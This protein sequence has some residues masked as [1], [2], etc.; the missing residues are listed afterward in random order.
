MSAVRLGGRP[1]R[2]SVHLGDDDPGVQMAKVALLFKQVPDGSARGFPGDNTVKSDPGILRRAHLGSGHPFEERGPVW[3][4]VRGDGGAGH[5]LD[6][7]MFSNNE[8][9][10]N[11]GQPICLEVDSRHPPKNTSVTRMKIGISIAPL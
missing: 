6:T 11:M 4:K 1:P 2:E 9:V 7:T 3:L 5:V 10:T 8:Q